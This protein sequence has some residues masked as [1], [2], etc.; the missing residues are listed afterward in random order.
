MGLATPRIDAQSRTRSD[1][2][3]GE[4]RQSS[5]APAPA[6]PLLTLQQQAGNHAV[7]SL[8]RGG[9]IQ[10][11]LTIS[12]PNDPEEREADQVA[13]RIM[14]S[15]GA[16]TSSSCSCSSGE[17]TCEE[18]QQKQQ[19]VVARSVS[20]IVQRQA[21]DPQTVPQANLPTSQ[22]TNS[23]AGSNPK[24]SLPWNPSAIS[25]G[26]QQTDSPYCYGESR[27]I[28]WFSHKPGHT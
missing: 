5:Y 14:R 20:N 19:G 13:D 11:K 6:H 16:P 1:C 23:P 2:H 9:L 8:L 21:A 18:C 22:P 26:I 4:R 3:S 15:H 27:R 10:P 17:D 12:Q 24:P 28:Q 25:S 7:Q